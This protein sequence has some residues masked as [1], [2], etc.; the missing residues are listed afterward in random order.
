MIPRIPFRPNFWEIKYLPKFKFNK[1]PNFKSKAV[2]ALRKISERLG[3]HQKIPSVLYKMLFVSVKDKGPLGQKGFQ[4]CHATMCTCQSTKWRRLARNSCCL[5]RIY[6][7]L[8]LPISRA[9]RVKSYTGLCCV[10][11]PWKWLTE[12]WIWPKCIV[13]SCSKRALS[14]TERKKYTA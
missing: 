3:I 13:L 6:S 11:P 14:K 1:I 7:C 5:S 8:V 4:G 9:L 2:Y 12:K 10:L